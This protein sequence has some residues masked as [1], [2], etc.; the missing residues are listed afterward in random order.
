MSTGYSRYLL[1]HF[2]FILDEFIRLFTRKY[3]ETAYAGL[4][5]RKIKA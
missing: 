5:K 2:K 4:F 1:G 3:K